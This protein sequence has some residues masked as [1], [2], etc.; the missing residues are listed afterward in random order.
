M[1]FDHRGRFDV[2]LNPGG[3]EGA[4]VRRYLTA[5]RVLFLAFRGAV[6]GQATGAHIHIG[7]PSTRTPKV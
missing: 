6:R 3:A 1:G 5:K 4:W 2:A 7:K